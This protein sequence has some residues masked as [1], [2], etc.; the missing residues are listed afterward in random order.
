[1]ELIDNVKLHFLLYLCDPH[2]VKM[3]EKLIEKEITQNCGRKLQYI[4]PMNSVN[5]IGFNIIFDIID[6]FS[7]SF[8]IQSNLLNPPP[9]VP[10]QLWADW[11]IAELSKSDCTHSTN[12]TMR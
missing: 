10:S 1:M 5:M 12:L 4:N 6:F 3:L 9:L 11:K 7:L 2:S 8:T